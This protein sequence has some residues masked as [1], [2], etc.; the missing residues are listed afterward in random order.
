MKKA[1]RELIAKFR[2]EVWPLIMPLSE[3]YRIQEKQ[4][5]EL[6]EC[7]KALQTNRTPFMAYALYNV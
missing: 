2:L 7:K 6:E 3:I 5:R 4:L 1:I